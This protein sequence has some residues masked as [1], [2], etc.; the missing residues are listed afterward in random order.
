M[1]RNRKKCSSAG[2]KGGTWLL[3][4]SN[5]VHSTS[6]ISGTVCFP[7]GKARTNAITVSFPRPGKLRLQRSL[8]VKR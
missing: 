8:A 3:T 6:R 5:A 4:L 7:L 2:L 1:L